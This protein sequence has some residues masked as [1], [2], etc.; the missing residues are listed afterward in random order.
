MSSEDNP[1]ASF[2]AVDAQFTDE[3]LV[4][5]CP[6]EPEAQR[7]FC[8]GQIVGQHLRLD[9]NKLILLSFGKKGASR[10]E[11]ISHRDND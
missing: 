8:E 10:Q 3:G 11:E 6:D 5:V 1:R 9:G 4:L 7:A 2:S